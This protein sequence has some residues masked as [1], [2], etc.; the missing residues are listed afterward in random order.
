MI[1]L[2]KQTEFVQADWLVRIE[3]HSNRDT[4]V[5]YT[6]ILCLLHMK[7]ILFLN[8][9]KYNFFLGLNVIDH[10]L[11]M[12]V[13]AQPFTLHMLGLEPVLYKVFGWYV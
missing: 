4:K 11:L 6:N 7:S 13:F 2:Q 3:I 9:Q 5:G 10:I 8:Y 12:I 1:A